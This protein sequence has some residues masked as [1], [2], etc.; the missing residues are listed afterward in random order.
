MINKTLQKKNICSDFFRES[1]IEKNQHE[2]LIIN[3]LKEFSILANKKE[4]NLEKTNLI[5][6]SNEKKWLNYF[7]YNNPIN[8]LFS[9]DQFLFEFAKKQPQR[10]KSSEFQQQLKEKKKLTLFYGHLSKKQLKNLLSQ[11]KTYP[12]SFSRNFFSI[13]ESRLD[14]LL[15]RTGLVKNILT[16]RQ[17]I[18]HKKIMVNNQIL[19]IASSQ[20][21]PGDII[22]IRSK[23]KNEIFT[24]F[25]QFIQAKFRKR[26]SRFTIT[27]NFLYKLEN[28]KN[29]KN[30]TQK[31]IVKNSIRLLLT[32]IEKRAYFKINANSFPFSSCFDLQKKTHSS[33][34]LYNKNQ[35]N[36]NR[37]FLQSKKEG[38][39]FSLLNG[40]TPLVN[41]G[42]NLTFVK[43]KPLLSKQ[44]KAFLLKCL[45]KNSLSLDRKPFFQNKNSRFLNLLEKFLFFDFF[46]FH[47]KKTHSSFFLDS[48]KKIQSKK[49]Q[50]KIES[51]KQ[52]NAFNLLT[53]KFSNSPLSSFFLQS[54]KEQKDSFG[55]NSTIFNK[56]R[57]GSFSFLKLKENSIYRNIV[58][59]TLLQMHS[60]FLYSGCF[61]SFLQN[62]KQK[63]QLNL[64]IKKRINTLFPLKLKKHILKRRSRKQI[65]KALRFCGMKPLH[66]EVS[67]N[68]STAIFLFSPQ[69]LSFPFSI[70]VDLI[71]RSFR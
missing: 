8:L 39:F 23:N 1:K 67:Y 16:A 49:D 52:S 19:N 45:Q 30:Y 59:K 24:P 37:S 32:K 14:I 25:S 61:V 50:K 34:F 28:R 10:R 7:F 55:K 58:Y 41:Q 22:A 54:K 3:K 62:K 36:M 68:M 33:F 2:L 43:F 35:I 21:N 56:T 53:R 9:I 63:K 15:S 12:G 64:K 51:K 46:L 29:L 13:L 48:K 69:R 65:L 47:K 5:T 27:Q 40:K 60:D 71:L 38:S 44:A 17:F 57:K 18:S 66:V 4:N 70:D 11:S 31:K 20:V 6:K 26:R 42:N